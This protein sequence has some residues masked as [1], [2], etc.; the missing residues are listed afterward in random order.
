MAY[1]HCTGRDNQS[2]RISLDNQGPH[3]SWKEKLQL[4]KENMMA[5]QIL[6][7][8]AIEDALFVGCDENQ[9]RNLLCQTVT[10]LPQPFSDDE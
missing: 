1:K 10:E 6:C 2:A 8:V 7:K 4:L 5:I 9:I 3:L